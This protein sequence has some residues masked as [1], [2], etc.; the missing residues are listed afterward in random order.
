MK[1]GKWMMVRDI[2][3]EIGFDMRLVGRSVGVIDK[4]FTF[5]SF[6]NPTKGKSWRSLY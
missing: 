3:G 1:Q 5:R 6:L 2:V 4:P